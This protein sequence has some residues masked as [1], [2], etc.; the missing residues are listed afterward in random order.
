MIPGFRF[1]GWDL[2]YTED[3]EWIIVEGNSITQFLG[4]QSTRNLGAKKSLIDLV[5]FTGDLY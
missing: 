5:G 3:N 1:I 4:Q 2:T